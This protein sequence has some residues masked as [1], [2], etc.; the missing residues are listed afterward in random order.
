[1]NTSVV[2][3]RIKPGSMDEAIH[4]YRQL[5]TPEVEEQYG[6]RGSILLVSRTKDTRVSITF[7][8]TLEDMVAGEESGFVLEQYQRYAGL[9]SAPPELEHFEV[10]Y[11]SS[12][13]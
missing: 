2:T 5:V 10:A 13:E 8:D 11:R 9:F 4:I 12:M 3:T 7:W 6:C 1:M